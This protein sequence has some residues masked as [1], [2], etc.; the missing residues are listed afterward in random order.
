M[1]DT[2]NKRCSAVLPLS[3]FRGILPV[4]DG[5]IG[6]YDREHV[7]YLYAGIS[8]LAIGAAV[9]VVAFDETMPCSAMAHSYGDDG[10]GAAVDYSGEITTPT[11]FRP[12]DATDAVWGGSPWGQHGWG[13]GRGERGWGCGVWGK[14]AWGRWQDA[15]ILELESPYALRETL[16]SQTFAVQAV[17]AGGTAVGTPAEVSIDLTSANAVAVKHIPNVAID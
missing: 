7:P 4:P 11:R 2:A 10:T 14:H 17:A 9:V 3:P 6:I 15:I 5:A 12:D 16:A 13:S 1:I 8:T